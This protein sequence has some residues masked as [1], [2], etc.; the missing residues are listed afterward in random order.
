MDNDT[1][2]NKNYL[3][4]EPAG[5]YYHPPVIIN[6]V[7]AAKPTHKFDYYGLDINS[8]LLLAFYFPKFHS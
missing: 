1:N 3:Q 5:T 8:T 2:V 4:I 6:S 7:L